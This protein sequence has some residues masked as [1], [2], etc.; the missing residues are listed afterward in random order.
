M[1]RS[2]RSS[3]F[4]GAVALAFVLF[5]PSRD[6]RAQ[7]PAPQQPAPQRPA[8]APAGPPA[9]VS[10]APPDLP[11]PPPPPW[12]AN[13][14]ATAQQPP[15][16]PPPDQTAP[17]T[18]VAPAAAPYVAPAPAPS[19]TLDPEQERRLG[20][21]ELHVR[22]LEEQH[23]RDMEEHEETLG[24]MRHVHISGY[25]QP[26]M[27]WQF[28]NA[29]ASPNVGSNGTLPSGVGANDVVASPNPLY[30]A[31]A[32]T[33]SNTSAFQLR[34]ARLQVEL[35]PNEYSRFV[36]EIDPIPLGGPEAGLGTIARNVEAD[37]I[38]HWNDDVRTEFGMGI[39]RVP[40]GYEMLEIDAHRPFIEH[41]WWE[42]NVF[43]DEFDTGAKAYTT[44][45]DH[46]LKVQVALLNGQMLGER[47]FAVVPDLNKGKDIVGRANYFF[48]AADFGISGY[49]GQGQEVV[50]SQLVFKQYPRWAFNVEAALHHRF[51]KIGETKVRGEF[52]LGQNMDRGIYYGAL[53]LPGLPS[54]I[55]NGSVVNRNEI[56]GF[57]RV[58]QDFTRW[59][60]LGVRYD[61]YSPDTSISDDGRH[62]IGVVGVAHFTRQLQLMVEYD[63]IIDNVRPSGSPEPNKLGDVLS[64]VFQVRYP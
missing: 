18:G 52:D 56:G 27:V 46:R 48:G 41:S 39:F 13:P 45:L 60:T 24:W 26:Q 22:Q 32:P 30:G 61:Y 21:L 9:A 28:Y 25:V 20:L 15:P 1:A 14:N 36:M 53:A 7:Q 50:L 33:T 34:R 5:A 23:R 64:T 2:S 51:L 8:A 12:T 58:E 4:T 55:V 44:A 47:T 16:A 29:A 11:P 54:D 40:F 19:S 31:T 6:A 37:G 10:P 3:C 38:V 49:Y 42:Q 43:P 57:I 62:T 63:H 59:A 17:A 35:E